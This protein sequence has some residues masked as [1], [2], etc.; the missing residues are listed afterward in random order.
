MS[1]FSVGA[2]EA[3]PLVGSSAPAG[4][5]GGAFMQ[6]TSYTFSTGDFNFI[7]AG[8]SPPDNFTGVRIASLPA[9]GNLTALGSGVGVGQV[10]SVQTIASGDLRFANAGIESTPYASFTFQVQDDGDTTGGGSNLDPTPNTFTLF[11]D[12]QRVDFVRNLYRDILNREAETEGLT[13]WLDQI[14]AGRSNSQIVSDLWNSYEHRALEVD[15]YYQQFFNRAPDL[16]GRQFWINQMLGGMDESDVMVAFLATEEFQLKNS[17]NQAF[18]A[19][20]YEDLFNRAPDTIGQEYWL[21]QL[22]SGQMT[23]QTVA[24][25]LVNTRER[26]I[27][28]VFGYYDDF[29]SRAPDSAGVE[30]WVDQLERNVLDDTGVA[31]ALLVTPEYL[32]QNA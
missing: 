3:E 29:Y 22:S 28:L 14:V 10:I 5:D 19:A 15:R 26:H 11:F 9:Q 2:P 31:E 30:F 7:D 23:R 4:L 13:G 32:N 1:P 25:N 12:D 24:N 27:D 8:D 6:G 17:T 20:V 21:D 18:L 16:A